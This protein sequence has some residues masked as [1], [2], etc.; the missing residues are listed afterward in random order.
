MGG[1]TVLGDGTLVIE[2]GSPARSIERLVKDKGGF[3]DCV[4]EDYGAVLLITAYQGVRSISTWLSWGKMLFVS[5]CDFRME[6]ISEYECC[7]ALH[8]MVRGKGAAPHLFHRQKAFYVFEKVIGLINER[9]QS[10]V[11]K[12]E[13]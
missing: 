10:G 5:G 13:I 7:D 4:A 1:F 11:Q 3:Q 2:R 12:S 8:R 9:R 6:E